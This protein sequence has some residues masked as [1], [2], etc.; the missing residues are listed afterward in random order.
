M[1]KTVVLPPV[2]D[3]NEKFLPLNDFPYSTLAPRI[4]RIRQRLTYTDPYYK[5]PDVPTDFVFV[6][7]PRTT[8]RDLFG[9]RF[10]HLFYED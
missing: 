2:P 5:Q 1:P 6:S 8:N 3:F 4:E 9:H 7:R 10:I